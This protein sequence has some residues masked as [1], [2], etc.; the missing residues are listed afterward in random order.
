MES[1]YEFVFQKTPARIEN[2]FG[3]LPQWSVTKLKSADAAVQYNFDCG[4]FLLRQKLMLK[5]FYVE[6]IQLKSDV[7]FSFRYKLK[8][9]RLFLFFM[10]EGFMDFSIGDTSSVISACKNNFYLWFN[11]P[12]VYEVNC[13]QG[14]ECALLIS[15]D[16]KNILEAASVYPNLMEVVIEMMEADESIR[17]FPS[18]PINNYVK[19][20]LNKLHSFAN[21]NRTILMGMLHVYVGE[22][23]EYYEELLIRSGVALVYRVRRFID[24]HYSDSSLNVARFTEIVC[25]S[26]TAL[27]QKFKMEFGV[28]LYEYLT[29]VRMLKAKEL[30]DAGAVP[31]SQ[32]WSEIGYNDPSTFNKAFNKFFPS[33]S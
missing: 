12:G 15:V 22:A 2:M 30:L 11:S 32:V 6:V 19:S 26:K 28:S 3:A 18:F 16:P 13:R 25:M 7:P 5:P 23:L 1:H 29:E 8:T 10:L 9:E 27:R 4:S 17:V 33:E 21:K 14:D 31:S 20:W 24:K